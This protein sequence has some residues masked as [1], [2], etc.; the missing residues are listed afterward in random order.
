M[1]SGVCTDSWEVLVLVHLYSF[2]LRASKLLRGRKY[3]HPPLSMGDKFQEPQRLPETV[4]STKTY[5]YYAFSYTYTPMIK[6]N[7]KIRHSKK[8]TTI[9]E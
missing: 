4:D 8:V 6:F 2:K 9:I 1:N 3:S 5:T 7:L